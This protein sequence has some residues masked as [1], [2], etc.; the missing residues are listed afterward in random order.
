[1]PAVC[2]SVDDSVL[3]VP[4]LPS[5]FRMSTMRGSETW[6][7]IFSIRGSRPASPA[8]PCGAA[9]SVDAIE[10]VSVR[11]SAMIG[12]ERVRR[13]VMPQEDTRSS[14]TGEPRTENVE[15]RT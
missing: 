6:E 9:V 10:M 5:F 3:R 8:G 14:G 1:M 11:A 7:R 2:E 4:K 15:V 12:N 13:G